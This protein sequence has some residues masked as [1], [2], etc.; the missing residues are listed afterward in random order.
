MPTLEVL[1]IGQLKPNLNTQDNENQRPKNKFK[2]L[3]IFIP[4]EVKANPMNYDAW[5]DLLRLLESDG[6]LEHTRDT[7]ERAIANIPPSQVCF[8]TQFI[9]IL[10]HFFSGFTQ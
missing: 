7:Y 10:L 8:T 1:C 3:Q 5:F 4:Q 6:E 9:C 2:Y